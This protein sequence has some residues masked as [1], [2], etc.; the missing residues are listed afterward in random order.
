MCRA[1]WC[2]CA[3]AHGWA[4]LLANVINVLSVVASSF[5][6]SEVVPLSPLFRP[7]QTTS[8]CLRCTMAEAPSRS[9]TEEML[10]QSNGYGVKIFMAGADE[11][12]MEEIA[13]V[14]EYKS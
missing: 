11:F 10:A 9:G 8:V 5:S 1:R 14:A 12:L 6:V 7:P 2:D 13:S 4:L 3:A